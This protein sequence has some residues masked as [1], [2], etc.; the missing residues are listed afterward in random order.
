MASSATLTSA[1]L[2]SPKPPLDMCVRL[3]LSV[4]MFLQFAVWG[5]YFT[6]WNVYLGTPV[7]DGGLGFTGTQIGSLYG[8]MALGAIISMMVAGQLADRV[9]SSEYLMAIFHVIGAVLLYSMSQIHNYNTL[10]YVSLL[11]ALMYNPTLAIANSLAFHN[12]P[13]ATR[14]FPTL[15]VLGTI[16]WIAAGMSI[17][18]VLPKGAAHTNKPLIMAA[19]LSAALGGFSLALPHTPPSGKAGGAMPFLRAFKLLRDPGFAIFFSISLVITIALAF[20]YT[21]AGPFLSSLN[22]K[23]IGSTMS[24]GQW[25]E[26]GFMLALPF[27]LKQ[28]GM[29]GVLAVGMAAWAVRYGLFSLG[30]PFVL[31]IIG[32]A[33]HGVCFDFFLA[34]GFIHTDNKAPVEIRGSAQG[35]FSFLTYGVGMWLGNEISGRVVD[36]FTGPTGINWSK[37]WA[38]PAVG[39]V[40][41]LLLFLVLWRDTEGKVDDEEPRGFPVHP[42]T[43]TTLP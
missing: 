16:G 25:S 13:D 15:R 34:A 30:H 10:W 7:A 27:A 19:V 26:I 33:L 2:D 20:Y 38:V 17:D 43:E 35:L 28:F 14:D 3:R 41:C 18:L 12:I 6:V 5:S 31:V 37:V 39:A 32:V 29:K 4:M 24:I 23:A 21:F 9:L 11:Y 42:V 1:S 22:V 40:I 36:H 8:T